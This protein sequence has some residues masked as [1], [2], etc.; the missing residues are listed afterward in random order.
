MTYCSS[1]HDLS[2]Y[3]LRRDFAR[4]M[5]LLLL[6]VL[7]AGCCTVLSGQERPALVVL[8]PVP[9]KDHTIFT[10]GPAISLRGAI[11]G[12]AN[13]MRVLWQS[14]RGFSDLAMVQRTAGGVLNWST[15]ATIPLRPG[16]NHVEI[17]ALEQPDWRH[18]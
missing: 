9:N 18:S 8:D 13:L 11:S 6:F 12:T 4:R 5:S 14:N 17:K 7:L 16:I 1:L 15:K 2:C 10:S 3:L